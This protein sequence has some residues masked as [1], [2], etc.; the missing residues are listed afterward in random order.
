MWAK[1]KKEKRRVSET[2]QGDRK[3]YILVQSFFSTGI[4]EILG[5]ISLFW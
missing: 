3:L 4:V 1:R 2:T 5:W